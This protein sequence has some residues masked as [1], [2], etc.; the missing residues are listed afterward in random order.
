MGAALL[1]SARYTYIVRKIKR[2]GAFGMRMFLKVLL[3]PLSLLLTIFVA[4]AMFVVG[5]CAVILNIFS[6]IMFLASLAGYAQYLFGWPMGS[7]G[8]MPTLQLAIFATV[9]AFLLSP[10]GLPAFAVWLV[11]KLDNLNCTIKSI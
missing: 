3:F 11:D 5:S 4:A 1:K 9:F 10:Y 7:A 6:G 2:K 8:N